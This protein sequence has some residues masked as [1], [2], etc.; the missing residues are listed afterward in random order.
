MN[1]EQAIVVKCKELQE[2]IEGTTT[3]VVRM[4]KEREERDK[5]IIGQMSQEIDE[6]VLKMQVE[7]DQFEGLQAKVN[8]VSQ[9]ITD[10][11]ES[12]LKIEKNEREKSEDTLLTLL[13]GICSKIEELS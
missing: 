1:R 4:E 13:E 11:I 8:K 2:N 6:L 12:D 9:E 3:S 7:E 5:T 10:Q